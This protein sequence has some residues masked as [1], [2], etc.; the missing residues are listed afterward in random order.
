MRW[1][2]RGFPAAER[3]ESVRVAMLNETT[4]GERTA[5]RAKEVLEATARLP[6][7]HNDV[8]QGASGGFYFN[9]VSDFA[10]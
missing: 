7:L 6:D 10:V 9:F 2:H 4:I 5:C 3:M 1:A 8:C